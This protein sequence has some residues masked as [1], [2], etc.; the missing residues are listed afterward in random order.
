MAALFVASVVLAVGCGG[1]ESVRVASSASDE[2][3]ATSTVDASA[4]EVETA[5]STAAEPHRPVVHSDA[6]YRVDVSTHVYGQGLSHAEWGGAPR[7]TVDL[8][9]DVYEPVGAPAG[10]PAMLVVH[11]GGFTS[12]S[13][14]SARYTEPAQYF[15]ERGWV[16]MSIDYR[17]A[18]QKGTL[19]DEWIDFVNSNIPAQGQAQGFALY[20]AA[21]DAK[22]ALRWLHA[23]AAE[24]QIDT[25]RV[26]A[27]GGSAGAFL[28]VMLGTSATDDFVAEISLDD[29]PTLETTNLS[30][31]ASV[32]VVLDHWGGPG[33]LE[34]LEGIDGVSRFDETD[35]PILIVH[36]TA[37]PTV[38]YEQSERL[39]AAYEQT[40]VPYELYPVEGGGHGIWNASIEGQ[41]LSELAFDFMVEHL[42]LDVR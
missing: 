38:P 8:L 26:A 32:H 30:A 20:P 23:N 5:E 15:A 9:L 34:I 35:V 16:T 14:T 4:A 42:L 18:G 3:R 7:G 29:D 37:D 12:G 1:D 25:A 6:T 2:V 22:A 10:R 27:F 24:Y 21:R 33:H 41:S 19:P 36:G 28:A 39:A 13:R 11:G 31:E 40:G 17:V